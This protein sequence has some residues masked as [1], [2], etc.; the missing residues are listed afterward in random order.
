M[1][2]DDASHYL[3]CYTSTRS[4]TVARE[5]RTIQPMSEAQR[6]ISNHRED[7]VSQRWHSLKSRWWLDVRQTG[8]CPCVRCGQRHQMIGM[9]FLK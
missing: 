2:I 1:L 5:S 7:A 9:G 4:P 8:M 6:L 3:F